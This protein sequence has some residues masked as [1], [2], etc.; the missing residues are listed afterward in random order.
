M[1][2]NLDYSTL[3]WVKGEID[4]TLTQARQALEAYVEN[5]DDET[6]IRFVVT[7]LHQVL[8][9]LKMVELYGAVM[10]AE[11]MEQVAE[12]LLNKEITQKAD[13][14]E[15]LMRAILQLPDYLES[16]QSGNKDVPMVLLPLLNDLRATRGKNLLSENALF[17]PDLTVATPDAGISTEYS[18]VEMSV[19]AKKL[20]H[21]YQTGLVGWFR[22]R[23]IEKSLQNLADVLSELR[24]VAQTDICKQL[25]WIANGVVEALQ[26]SGLDSSVSLKLLLGQVD[27]QIKKLVDGGGVERIIAE[28]P[29]GVWS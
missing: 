19:V 10:L 28:I 24:K 29:A 12:A 18:G 1:A 14:Y 15:V 8:G 27:R 7:Y 20:R 22:E 9:T 17:A 4:E 3:N 21:T 2:E 16:L 5:P 23:N 13:A 11:E 25:F 6:Q 26:K